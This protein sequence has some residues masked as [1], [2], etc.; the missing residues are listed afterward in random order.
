MKTWEPPEDLF[1]RDRRASAPASISLSRPPAGPPH[2]LLAH[3]LLH[4]SEQVTELKTI[5]DSAVEKMLQLLERVD[6]LAATIDRQ[7]PELA[8][9]RRQV[10]EPRPQ[11]GSA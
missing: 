5:T 3:G 10:A 8:D 7:Q 6:A 4:V 2:A 9:L 11:G 1:P